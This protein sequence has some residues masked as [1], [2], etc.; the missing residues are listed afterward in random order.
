M[1]FLTCS[2]HQSC[3]TGRKNQLLTVSVTGVTPAELHPHISTRQRLLITGLTPHLRGRPLVDAYAYVIRQGQRKPPTSDQQ[4]YLS[5]S[6]IL[7]QGGK[8]AIGSK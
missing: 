8:V 2:S 6:L 1:P 4:N 3:I 7:L 5:L